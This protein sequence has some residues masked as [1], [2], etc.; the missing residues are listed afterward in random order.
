MIKS[1][2]DYIY[3]LEQDKRALGIKKKFPLLHD[4]TCIMLTQPCYKF[5]KLLR[6]LEYYTNCKNKG[7]YRLYIIFLRYRFQ[8]VSINLGFSIPIN[9]F[10][11]GLCINHFGS[12]IVS[13]HAKVGRNCLINSAVNIGGSQECEAAEIGDNCYI[14]P[15]VKILGKIKIGNDVA[16]G[17]NAVVNKD[18][19]YDS[20]TIAGIPAR[21]ISNKGSKKLIKG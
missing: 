10:G 19:E 20:I 13:R 5:Q 7:L 9:V 15:G 8:K 1:K 11:P 3:Y 12:I 16:I 6:R 4:N 14:G 18:F 21:I 17:A 2:E